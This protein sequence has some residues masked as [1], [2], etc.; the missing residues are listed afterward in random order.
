MTIDQ[1]LQLWD[2]SVLALLVLGVSL[3]LARRWWPW[4]VAHVD[5][6]EERQHELKLLYIESDKGT[7]RAITLGAAALT[8]L[9]AAV[10]DCPLQR[11]CPPDTT[12]PANTP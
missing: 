4:W 2:Q 10:A 1:I 9:A 3:F 12:E 5:G 6:Q 8:A 7:A 11:P